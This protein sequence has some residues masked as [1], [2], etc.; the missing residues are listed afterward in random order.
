[1]FGHEKG[2]FTG[3]SRQKPGCFERAR[4]GSLFLDEITEIPS[5]CQIDLLRV[6]ETQQFTRVGGE[7]GLTSDVRLISAT[8][9]TAVSEI[10][11]GT[12]REDLY[13]RLNIV[14]IQIPPC[15]SDAM[16]YHS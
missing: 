8:N 13:Y 11:E 9:K 2:A 7:E 14:P 10:E 12:F 1:M 3:A 15:A 6:L 5:K 16:I 4:G